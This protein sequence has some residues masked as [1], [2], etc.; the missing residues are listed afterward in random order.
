MMRDE[1]RDHLPDWKRICSELMSDPAEHKALVSELSA[2]AEY[3]RQKPKM[4]KDMG[5][6][7]EVLERAM[8]RCIAIA[9]TVF[10]GCQ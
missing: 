1:G 8:G 7:P 3:L 5:G 4:A 10:A 2:L 9:D 6:S